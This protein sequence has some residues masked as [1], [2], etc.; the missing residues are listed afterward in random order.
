MRTRVFRWRAIGPLLVAAL[1]LAILWVLFADTIVRRET[2][3]AGTEL[4]GARVEIDDLHLDLANGDVTIRGLTIAS[5]HEPFRNLLQADEL[6][7]DLDVLALTEK[8]IVIDRLAANGL[9]F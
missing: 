3:Q 5:P 4:L 2:E 1:V 6:V 9:R 7:A 8:K